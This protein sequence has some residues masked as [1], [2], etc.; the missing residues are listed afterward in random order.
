[1]SDFAAQ[2]SEFIQEVS[3]IQDEQKFSELVQAY[4]ELKARDLEAIKQKLRRPMRKKLDPE[5]IKRAR[6]FK[7]HNKEEIFRLIKEIDIQE[8]IELL[9]SQLTK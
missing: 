2:K 5:A 6:G 8:P 1:M 9:L 3:A 4:Q 7:G